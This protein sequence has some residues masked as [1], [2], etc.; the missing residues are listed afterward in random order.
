MAQFILSIP[1][2][3]AIRI[4]KTANGPQF[5][6]PWQPGPRAALALNK[7]ITDEYV[8]LVSVPLSWKTSLFVQP[9]GQNQ[10][11]RMEHICSSW[12]YL[13]ED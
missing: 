4:K 5:D 9:S 11:G 7:G 12:L 10:V 8:L 2:E 1:K 13:H 6:R 3:K